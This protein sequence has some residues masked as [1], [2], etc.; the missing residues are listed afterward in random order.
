MSL[1]IIKKSKDKNDNTIYEVY[2]FKEK[3]C[4]AI[5][6]H[7]LDSYSYNFDINIPDGVNFRGTPLELKRHL[8]NIVDKY[9][10]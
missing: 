1:S 4:E 7:K 6:H 5:Y 9:Y 8:E 2:R 10:H 3:I